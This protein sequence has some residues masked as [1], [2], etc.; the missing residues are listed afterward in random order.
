MHLV[1]RPNRLPATSEVRLVGDDD[2]RETPPFQLFQTRQPVRRNNELVH[3]PGGAGL[4]VG[5]Q[6]LVE[7]AVPVQKDCPRSRPNHRTDSRFVSTCLGAGCET[8]KC[9]T[10]AWKASAC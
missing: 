7:D 1:E 8:N 2:E 6:R 4:T 9:Q 3:I 10:V 5:D